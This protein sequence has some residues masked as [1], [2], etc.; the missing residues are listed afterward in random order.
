MYVLRIV[1][2]ISFTMEHLFPQQLGT[3]CNNSKFKG[4][5]YHFWILFFVFSEMG[6]ITGEIM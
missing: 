1:T 6:K 2:N 5:V 3:T 4:I